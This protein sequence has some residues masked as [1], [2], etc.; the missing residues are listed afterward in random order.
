MVP[1]S[2]QCGGMA[3]RSLGELSRRECFEL[4][5]RQRVGRIVYSDATGP[6]AIPV[7][8]ATAGESIVFRVEPGH[9]L[10]PITHP[11]MAFEVDQVDEEDGSGWSVL[12]RGP[13]RE[14]SLDDVPA[15]L[16][17]MGGG[18]PRPWAEGIHKV[19]VQLSAEA[20][21]GRRLGAYEAPLVM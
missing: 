17:T 8:F 12:V 18:P 10:L 19:W 4:L 14:V 11:V 9:S 13:A 20:V 2:R 21:T 1:A 16:R 3:Q 5:A 15:L 6:L 7:N